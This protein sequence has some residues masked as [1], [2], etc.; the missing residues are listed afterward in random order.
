MTE[1]QDKNLPVWFKNNSYCLF[2]IKEAI[3]EAL[4]PDK[5]IGNEWFGRGKWNDQGRE[6]MCFAP[7][8]SFSFSSFERGVPQSGRR[9]GA[10]EWRDAD[11]VAEEEDWRKEVNRTKQIRNTNQEI[12]GNFQNFNF[13]I[14]IFTPVKAYFTITN[15]FINLKKN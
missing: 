11:C 1:K 8:H 6:M 12:L 10:Q 4:A 9:P 14:S 13:F 15:R 5:G 3:L 2:L 7:K